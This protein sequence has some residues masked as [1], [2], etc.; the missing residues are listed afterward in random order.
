MV[1]VAVQEGW[2]CGGSGGVAVPGLPVGPFAGQGSVESFDLAVGLWAVGRVYL[3]VTSP[4]AS[5]KTAER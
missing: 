3:W 2:E 5:L 1:V 4:R